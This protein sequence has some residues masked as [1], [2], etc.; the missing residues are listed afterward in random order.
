ML[1][2]GKSPS[3]ALFWYATAQAASGWSDLAGQGQ[4]RFSALLLLD[5]H[6]IVAMAAT[7]FIW[8][9]RKRVFAAP[10]WSDLRLSA[11]PPSSARWKS[12]TLVAIGGVRKPLAPMT[13]SGSGVSGGLY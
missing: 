3:T 11:P 1:L 4:C 13:M 5:P 12:V 2:V 6:Y 9:A 8:T 7:S 10:V